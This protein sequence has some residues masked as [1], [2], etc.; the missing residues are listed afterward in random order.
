MAVKNKVQLITYPDSM[1]GSL[2]ALKQVLDTKLEGVFEGGVHILPPF[3]SSG[4]RGFAPKTYLEIEPTFGTWQDIKE[5]GERRDVV[6]DLMVNHISKESEYFRDFLQ[7]G[8]ASPYADYFITLDKLWEDKLPKKEDVDKIFLR[9]PLP[10]SRYK[11]AGQ[12]ELIWTTFGQTE[13]SEQVDLD[14]YSQAVR[15]LFVAIFQKFSENNITVVRLDAVGYVVKKLGTSCFFVEPE[16]YQFLDWICETAGKYGIEL[17]PEVHAE[18][19]V[20]NNLLQHGFWIYDF[21]LPYRTLEMLLCKTSGAMQQ[22]LRIRPAHQFTTLD[23][24]DGVPIKPDL[25]GM[26]EPDKAQEVSRSCVAHGCNLSRILSQSHKDADGF[27]VHQICGTYF[28][29]LGYDEKAYLAARAVQLFVPG[30]PQVYYTGLLAGENHPER[31]RETGDG[32]EINRHNYSMEELEQ[33]LQE[34]IV[35]RLC[36]LMRFRNHCACFDGSFACLPSDDRHLLLQWSKEDETCLLQLDL[37]GCEMTIR[38]TKAGAT[39]EI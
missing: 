29:M 18:F 35:Q 1:G 25:D 21:V 11:V 39:V 10:Y 28:S 22:Y 36:V 38:H 8:F 12:D 33:R 31:L 32:R 6:V 30:V 23:C 5:I 13:P 16:I 37:S 14:V 7:N 3:P 4:D 9:R 17:L 24:H 19:A 20:Q 34:P 27:D 15:E 2:A 26:Y